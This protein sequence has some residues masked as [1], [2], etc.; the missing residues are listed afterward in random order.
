MP[1]EIQVN[2]R[3]NERPAATKPYPSGPIPTSD[4]EKMA[5]NIHPTT[6]APRLNTK[7]YPPPPMI[8]WAAISSFSK[9]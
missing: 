5:A 8:F 4:L 1:P 3:L 6:P 2:A 7:R 9:D